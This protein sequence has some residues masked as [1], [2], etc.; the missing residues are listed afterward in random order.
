MLVKFAHAIIQHFGVEYF[1][2]IYHNGEEYI[3][4]S[5]DYHHEPDGREPLTIV[6][7]RSPR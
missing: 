2:P 1:T 3:V 4:I 7:E 6:A 5:T